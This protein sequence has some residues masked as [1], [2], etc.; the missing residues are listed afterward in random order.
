MKELTVKERDAGGRLDKFLKHYLP[1]A[2]TGFLYKMLRKKNILLNG[3]KAEGKELLRAGDV[4]RIY[5][6]DETMEKFRGEPKENTEGPKPGFEIPVLYEDEEYLFFDKPAGLLSQKASAGDYSLAEYLLDYLRK[7]GA[8]SAEEESSFT[9]APA[10]R[11]DR[12]TSGIVACGKTRRGLQYLS[13]ALKERS[14]NK[15]YLCILKGDFKDFGPVNGYL[16]KDEE[17]N[18]ASYSERPKEGYQKV[19]IEVLPEKEF[20][21][22]K[23]EHGASVVRIKLLTGKTHQIRAQLSAL[24]HPILGDPKYGDKALNESLKKLGIRRQLLHAYRIGFPKEA[25][26]KLS[27]REI[28]APLPND[29]STMIAG[30]GI[31]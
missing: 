6:S 8:L 23:K 28:T 4:I 27:G 18:L 5:F 3:K 20:A 31:A 14:L 22:C 2:T 15:E 24:G 11:L 10:H 17:Q 13:K 30:K 1:D 21:L 26:G 9:P 19:A 12:N 7:E 25:P 29:L 16:K